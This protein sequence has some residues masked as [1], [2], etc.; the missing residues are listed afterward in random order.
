MLDDTLTEFSNAPAQ[1][2]P[3]AGRDIFWF[4]QM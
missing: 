1:P 2:T 4:E 3:I